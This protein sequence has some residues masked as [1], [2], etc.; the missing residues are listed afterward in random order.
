MFKSKW[1]WRDLC[2]NSQAITTFHLKKR[3]NLLSADGSLVGWRGPVVRVVLFCWLLDRISI[4]ASFLDTEAME[5]LNREVLEDIYWS[6]EQSILHNANI[7][8][9]GWEVHCEWLRRSL[10]ILVEFTGKEFGSETWRSHGYCYL[11]VMPSLGKDDRFCRTGEG[12]DNQGL[13]SAVINLWLVAF[14][15]L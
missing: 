1:R 15:D 9:R 10:C 7:F 12:Q 14:L 3:C 11:C 8:G 2:W 5:L 13:G 6:Y 4:F